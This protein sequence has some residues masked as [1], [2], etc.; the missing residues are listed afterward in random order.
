[1]VGRRFAWVV[2]LF[3][4]STGRAQPARAEE[5]RSEENRPARPL[6]LLVGGIVEDLAQPSEVWGRLA[7]DGDG[8]PRWN[9]MV[10]A[11]ETAG[12]RFGGVLRPAQAHWNCRAIWIGPERASSRP[13]P[14]SFGCS[15]PAMRPPTAWR[16]NPW[17]WPAPSP[18]CAG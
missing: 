1:M 14:M 8:P 5:N 11:L 4:A 2:L 10:G 12:Y 17:N 6:V 9:G 18:G 13:R 3:I 15:S 7:A 16:S